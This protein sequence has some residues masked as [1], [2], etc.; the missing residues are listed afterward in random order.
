M[1]GMLVLAVVGVARADDVVRLPAWGDG[2][3]RVAGPLWATL[4]LYGRLPTPLAGELHGWRLT[5]GGAAAGVALA[6]DGA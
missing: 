5:E 2:G 4:H 3:L 1:V 6:G